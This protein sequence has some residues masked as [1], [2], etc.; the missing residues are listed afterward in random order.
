ML[1]IRGR[2]VKEASK[3]AGCKHQQ[4]K[5]WAGCNTFAAEAERQGLRSIDVFDLRLNPYWTFLPQYFVDLRS[6]D[7][8]SW[9]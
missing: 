3:I 7:Y 5:M 2:F 4:D 8:Y 6:S 1:D 9:R